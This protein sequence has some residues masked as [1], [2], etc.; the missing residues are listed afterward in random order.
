MTPPFPQTSPAQKSQKLITQDIRSHFQLLATC[1]VP[2]LDEQAV[3][4]PDDQAEEGGRL[5]RDLEKR[6]IAT[7]ASPFVVNDGGEEKAG[8]V[9]GQSC[10][11]STIALCFVP[12]STGT[13]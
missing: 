3:L 5:T 6:K 4:E 1:Y 13:R 9:R 2:V 7:S 8:A 10:F 11:L 12:R